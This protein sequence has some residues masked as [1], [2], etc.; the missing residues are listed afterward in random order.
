MKQK[1]IDFINFK[2]LITEKILKWV[3][4][5]LAALMTLGTVIAIFASWVS[6]FRVIRYSFIRFLGQAIGVPIL[7]VILLAISLVI[8]RIAFESLLIRFLIYRETKEL[9]EKTAPA[10]TPAES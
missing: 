8:L 4:L 1:V 7:A 9:N 5:V 6:A 3:F 2:S 10:E